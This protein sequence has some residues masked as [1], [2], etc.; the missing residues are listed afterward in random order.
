[1]SG[2]FECKICGNISQN[3][4]FIA[5]ERLL[6]IRDEFI[7]FE[8]SRCC[9]VQIQKVPENIAKYYPNEY[10]SYQEP[11]FANKL[12]PILFFL[13]K[14]LAKYYVGKFNLT[15]WM[16]SFFI[17][18]PF[19]WLKSDL[20][21]LGSKILDVGCGSGRKL[22]SM[23]RSGFTNLI[24]IDPFNNSDI[25]YDNGLKVLKMEVFEINEKY[26]FIMLHHSFEHMDSPLKVLLKLKEL[27]NPESQLLIRIPVANSY[28]WRKYKA[29]WYDLD[30]PRHLFLHTTQSIQL[31]AESAGLK[32][33]RIDYDSL[34]SQLM[35]SEKYLRNM[36]STEEKNLFTKKEI[37][38]FSK[39]VKRLNQ[40]NDGGSACFYLTKIDTA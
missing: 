34:P 5:T 19:P 32:I 31:L 8:C 9:C 26:D 1:M 13:K 40:I 39:E 11:S 23:Q 17:D 27:L 6:G 15:G 2:E 14:S 28:A 24:G 18:H 37:K 7:Y 35:F 22:L 25:I 29:F 16:L 33:E 12:N 20:V 10:Y 36:L 21:D 4:S 38:H 3:K 30:A